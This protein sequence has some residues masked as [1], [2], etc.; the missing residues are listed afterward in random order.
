MSK[1]FALSG[2]WIVVSGEFLAR[3]IHENY[4]RSAGLKIFHIEF[5]ECFIF[6]IT[7]PIEHS[8]HGEHLETSSLVSVLYLREL[9]AKFFPSLNCPKK[10]MSSH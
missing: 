8:G 2:N 6:A 3:L 10:F 5:T 1:R 7:E 9:C 4:E